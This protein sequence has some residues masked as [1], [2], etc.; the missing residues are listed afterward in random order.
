MKKVLISLTVLL[1]T[2]LFL[3]ACSD[4]TEQN[5][6]IDKE[7]ETKTE[8]Q[9][10]NAAE[11][12]NETK[13]EDHDTESNSEETETDNDHSDV[14]S[15][16]NDNTE[17]PDNQSNDTKDS[18]LSAYSS[19]EIEYARIWLQLGEVEDVD[20]LNVTYISAGEPL[21]PNDETSLDYPEDVVQ[22][23]GSR[24]I[25]GSIIYS[26]NGDGTINLYRKVPQRWDGKNPAGEDAYKQIIDDIE[27]VSIDTG[28]DEKKLKRLRFILKQYRVFS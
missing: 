24:L 17:N 8:D 23:A 2:P 1:M 9:Q 26:S 21:N 28:D 7:K 4:D 15:S 11:N 19:E 14:T 22:L 20:E 6:A 10:N 5:E 18:A 25:D 3:I 27:Q 12:N 13:K 16:E